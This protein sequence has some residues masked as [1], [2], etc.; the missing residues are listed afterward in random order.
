MGP[1]SIWCVVAITARI[2]DILQITAK[3][4]KFIKELKSSGTAS[5]AVLPFLQGH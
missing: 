5:L 2:G 3:S 1:V 4:I